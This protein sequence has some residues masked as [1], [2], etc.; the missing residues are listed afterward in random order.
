MVKKRAEGL[1]VHLVVIFGAVYGLA[2]WIGVRLLQG[3]KLEICVFYGLDAWRKLHQ[4]IGILSVVPAILAVLVLI[5][6]EQGYLREALH[7]LFYVLRYFLAVQAL[8]VFSSLFVG[9]LLSSFLAMGGSADLLI[10]LAILLFWWVILWMKPV[11]RVTGILIPGGNVYLVLFCAAVLLTLLTIQPVTDWAERQV[12][13]GCHALHL[14]YRPAFTWRLIGAA[15]SVPLLAKCW[16][17]IGR[18]FN[19]D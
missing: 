19:L 2:A 5:R 13:Q 11:T 17:Q 8:A 14:S 6:L 12:Q 16:N 9:Q 7:R 18:F 4:T 3:K 1:G 10:W 15:G